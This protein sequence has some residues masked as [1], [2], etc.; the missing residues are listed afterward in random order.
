MSLIA[1][2]LGSKNAR[3]T[4]QLSSTI[5]LGVS[6]DGSVTGDAP[7]T[8]DASGSIALSVSSS[9]SIGSSYD[10]T[11]ISNLVAYFDSA[12]PAS[13]TAS[14]NAIGQW[15]DKSGNGNHAVQ[16]TTAQK[17]VYGTDTINGKNVLTFNADAVRNLIL[18]AGVCSI[19]TSASEWTFFAVHKTTAP[20]VTN[21]VLCG[22][23]YSTLVQGLFTTSTAACNSRQTSSKT[24]SATG[25]TDTGVHILAGRR[26]SGTLQAYLDGN[27]KSGSNTGVSSTTI[28]DMSIG[29]TTTSVQGYLG[30]I[31]MFN[32]A[33]T[34]A[35]YNYIVAGL[36]AKFGVTVTTL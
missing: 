3:L 20:T 21:R 25:A 33:L 26:S 24:A 27:T 34:D 16:T 6:G 12:D 22:F 15:S 7:A 36:A 17:P 4:G 18:P 28:T 2:L 29:A 14:S 23:T 9:G 8:G 5:A 10:P 11:T 13:V 30:D 19:F 32:R 1:V 31:L 35:E